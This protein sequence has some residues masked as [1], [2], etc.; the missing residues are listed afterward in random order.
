[1]HHTYCFCRQ[2]EEGTIDKKIYLIRHCAA[3]GQ[4]SESQLTESGFKQAVYLS[5]FFTNMKVDR[6]ISSPFLRAIQTIEPLAEKKNMK[7]E[8]NRKL[9]ERILSTKNLPDWFEKLE[10][11]FTDLQPEI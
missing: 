3:K 11:T 10:E 1:M 2:P 7:V 9:S 6:I 4:S 8:I 5:E